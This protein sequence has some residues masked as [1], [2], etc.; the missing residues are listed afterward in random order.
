M[1]ND[2]TWIKLWRKSLQWQWWTDPVVAHLFLTMLMKANI[3][4][5][6]FQGT[7]IPEGSFVSSYSS[8]AA[9]SGLTIKQVRRAIKCLTNTQEIT[10]RGHS[11]Y[12]V[13]TIVEWD[14]YQ[15]KRTHK[16]QSEGN[17]RAFKGQQNKN[18]KNIK[19]EKEYICSDELENKP[20]VFEYDLNIVTADDED[21]ILTDS[22]V[23]EWERIHGVQWEGLRNGYK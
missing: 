8:L 6:Y 15:N 13:F 1:F 16:G 7:F 14:S 21:V 5:S 2:D 17:Q 4:D 18:N 11:K 10:H 19:E 12:S 3:K 20:K 23:E 22:Q 9:A